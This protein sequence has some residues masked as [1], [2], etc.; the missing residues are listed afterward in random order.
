CR[1]A[2][3]GRCGSERPRLAQRSGRPKAGT[4]RASTVAI[5]E[6]EVAEMPVTV[7]VDPAGNNEQATGPRGWKEKLWR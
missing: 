2:A 1:C 3:G 4:P 6:V 7:A 5:H